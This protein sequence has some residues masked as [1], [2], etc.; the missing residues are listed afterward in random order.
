MASTFLTGDFLLY[1]W[2]GMA[3][4]NLVRRYLHQ[5]GTPIRVAARFLKAQEEEQSKDEDEGSEASQDDAQSE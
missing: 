4:E 2:L 5:Q 3:T 1:R